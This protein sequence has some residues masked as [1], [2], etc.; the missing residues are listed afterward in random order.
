MPDTTLIRPTEAQTRPAVRP[1]RWAVDTEQ[2]RLAF[3]I[4]HLLVAT[5]SGV[6]LRFESELETGPSGL[7]CATG[8]VRT[9]SL[10]TGDPTRDQVVLGPGFL[11]GETHPDIVFASSEVEQDDDGAVRVLG[12]LTIR[13]ITRPVVLV[14]SVTAMPGGPDQHERIAIDAR[15][16]ISRSE[17]GVTG[18]GILERSG[19]ALS[20]TVKID[21]QVCAV[22][23]PED[24]R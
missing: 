13:G 9:A 16:A 4:R 1:G 7:V 24:E 17:F 18:G 2:S 12:D 5:M 21:L 19:A 20:D 23:V 11:D 8:V 3:T 10:D 22:S 6:F 14:G 15:G